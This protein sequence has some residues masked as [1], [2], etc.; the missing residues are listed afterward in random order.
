MTTIDIHNW[1]GNE[2]STEFTDFVVTGMLEAKATGSVQT[3][4][5]VNSIKL[6]KIRDGFSVYSDRADFPP[7]SRGK[8]RYYTYV[9]HEIG[10]APKGPGAFPFIHQ[11]F[12]TIGDSDNLVNSNR[13]VYGAYKARRPSG[14]RGA[15][16]STISSSDLAPV[17][18]YL[19]RQGRKNK[20]K[21]PRALQK[22]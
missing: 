4:R 18:A 17:N 21:I 6:K 11:A 2:F 5:M 19:G 3:G 13:G 9:Y 7:T 14:R 16:V 20:V 12:G 15:G 8:S 10:Y 22:Q 1:K